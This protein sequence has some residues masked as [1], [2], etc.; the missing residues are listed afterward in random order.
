LD[1]KYGKTL[2][3]AL[4]AVTLSAFTVPFC[5][6][7]SASTGT[8]ITRNAASSSIQLAQVE[9][10]ET[11]EK[12]EHKTKEIQGGAEVVPGPAVSAPVV[13]GAVEQKREESKTTERVHSEDGMSG[14]SERHEN[15]M[16]NDAKVA[17]GAVE[18]EHEEHETHEKIEQNP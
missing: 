6:T 14:T 17:P 8:T 7:A 15:E 10:Q 2:V 5:A 3:G 4:A 18:R 16:S 12:T 9:Q 1:M 13:P 11:E